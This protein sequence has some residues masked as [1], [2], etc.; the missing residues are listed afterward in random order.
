[1]QR[2]LQMM[3]LSFLLLGSAS[4]ALVP[5]V[6]NHQG[7]LTND[8]G[9]PLS[10]NYEMTFRFYHEE[11]GGTAL[12]TEVQTV[13]AF[14]GIFNV[15]LGDVTPLEEVLFTGQELYLGITM[16][17]DS[18]MTPRM[19]TGSVMF[20]MAANQTTTDPPT[21]YYDFDNDTFGDP[22]V[23]QTAFDQPAGYVQ[24][25]ADCDDN[26]PEIHP[27]GTEYCDGIDSDCDG[28][29]DNDV[30]GPP[31]ALAGVG[32]CAG[33][34]PCDGAS[35]WGECGAEEYGPDYQEYETL[36][37]GLDNDCDG[38][39]DENA[40]CYDGIDCTLDI[41][42]MEMGCINPPISGTCFIDG[43]CYEDGED[44]RFNECLECNVAVSQTS[45][46]PVSNGTACNGGVC[47]NGECQ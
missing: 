36:C 16:A 22:L 43:E 19:R 11:S 42:D 45:W 39:V 33:T 14:E 44:N 4:L 26:D 13:T 24:N 17:G 46:T 5:A 31:C 38:D 37:D 41:C 8:A 1:M 6:I 2:V 23:F 21:W 35:G 40:D 32:I 3:I 27:G 25:N 28:D 7:R 9:V 10:G 15:Y 29:P 34:K 12:W 20:A 18:E 47:Q 30:T